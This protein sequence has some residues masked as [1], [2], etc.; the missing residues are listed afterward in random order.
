MAFESC[1]CLWASNLKYKVHVAC[2]VW[3]C[4][5][6]SQVKQFEAQHTKLTYQI[7]KSG[8]GQQPNKLF[9]HLIHKMMMWWLQ[10]ISLNW[11]HFKRTQ[12]ESYHQTIKRSIYQIACIR[13][14]NL[15]PTHRHTHVC[16]SMVISE[17]QFYALPQISCL[18]AFNTS[19]E[20]AREE[21]IVM[22]I[23]DVH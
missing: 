13:N 1:W 8:R 23:A 21:L 6:H 12:R 22:S 7:T 3:K 2:R 9:I 14:E 15:G 16:I 4:Y 10:N 11:K 19:Y 20:A 18:S 5:R 17:C